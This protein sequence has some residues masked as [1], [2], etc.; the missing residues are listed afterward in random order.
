MPYILSKLAN[1]Q[2]Y[3]QYAKGMNNLNI[4]VKTVV[5]QGGA[6]VT[7]KNFITPE[8]VI[9]KVSADDLESLKANRDFQRH[10]ERG[11]VKYFGTNPNMDKEVSK[12][13]KDNSKPL[14]PEDYTKQGKKTPKT[15]K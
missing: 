4:P 3:T 15:E 2:V 5:V 7:N 1:T 10:I 14:T 9:T 13:E 11:V 8:G 12:M 6:D